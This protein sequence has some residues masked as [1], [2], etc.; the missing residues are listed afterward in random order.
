[1]SRIVKILLFIAGT[2]SIV[3]AVIGMFLPLLPTTPFLLLAAYCYA[4]S[5]QRFYG[6]LLSNRYFGTYIKN[7][8]EGRGITLQHKVISIAL[9]WLTIGYT[10]L[11]V[12][13][14]WWGKALLVCVVIG[15]TFHLAR[16]KTLVSSSKQNRTTD[17][18]PI[19]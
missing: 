8:R 15:V 4:R 5:S 17:E 11:F 12:V 10:T 19:P 6:W 16:M 2:L 14:P 13:E 9:L 3:F 18:D 7:Y 1:M